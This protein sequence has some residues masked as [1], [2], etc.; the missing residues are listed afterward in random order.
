MK[1]YNFSFTATPRTDERER[2]NDLTACDIT[3]NTHVRTIKIKRTGGSSFGVVFFNTRIGRERYA[4]VS[5]DENSTSSP[6]TIIRN[7][8]KK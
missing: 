7:K 1:A 3:M 8:R 4:R 6:T 2:E 5:Y